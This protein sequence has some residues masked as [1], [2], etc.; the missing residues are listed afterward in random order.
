VTHRRGVV[1]A[2]K[3][4]VV[5]AGARARRRLHASVDR[6]DLPELP[7]DARTFAAEPLSEPANDVIA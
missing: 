2:K 3:P 6:V 7:L 5:T 1:T 4:N